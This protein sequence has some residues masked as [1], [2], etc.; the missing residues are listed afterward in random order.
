MRSWPYG[1]SS[2]AWASSFHPETKTHPH[3][4]FPRC[5][6]TGSPPH[7]IQNP[8]PPITFP[9]SHHPPS[10]SSPSSHSSPST[11]PVPAMPPTRSN[12]SATVLSSDNASPSPEPQ[13]PKELPERSRNAKAQ[14][15]H[16]EKRKAYISHVRY[17]PSLSMWIRIAHWLNL[18]TLRYAL[19][20]SFN[21]LSHRLV[22]V[23]AAIHGQRH[24]LSI[25]RPSFWSKLQ[26]TCFTS[27]NDIPC[28]YNPPLL[29][30][31]RAIRRYPQTA[32][33]Q[34]G[35]LRRNPSPRTRIVFLLRLPNG[36]RRSPPRTRRRKRATENRDST[37]SC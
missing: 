29:T 31:A 32:T 24:V 27:S 17:A 1:H 34:H 20:L 7:P 26:S 35:H 36:K 2:V 14:A 37:S 15:R 13:G 25:H 21:G 30:T 28:S 11:N 12:T 23:F 4:P 9:A 19:C 18:S 6:R 3:P 22:L 5:R 16:R 33:S 10:P 8:A